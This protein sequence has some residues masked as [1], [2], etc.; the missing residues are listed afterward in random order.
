VSKITPKTAV[1]RGNLTWLGSSG[2]ALFLYHGPDDGGTN[3][4]AWANEVR[5]P[6]PMNVGF[7]DIGISHAA[8]NRAWCYRWCATNLQ[9]AAWSD[10]TGGLILGAVEVKVTRRESTEEKP[11]EFVIFRPATAANGPLDVYFKLGGTGINGT[12]YERL[13]SPVVIPAGKSEVQ[14]PVNPVFSLGVKQPKSVELTIDP[15]GYLIGAKK[16]AQI[17]TRPQ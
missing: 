3:R 5:L 7:H 16:S 11:A 6:G 12:D 13:D 10:S 17:L 14:L 9:G 1:V 4:Q 8:S 2:A 15:G